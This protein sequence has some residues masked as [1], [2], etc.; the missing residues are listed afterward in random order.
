MA[1]TVPEVRYIST[2]GGSPPLSFTETLLAGLAPD[3]GLYVP[4]TYPRL[5]H[6]E[7]EAFA[8]KPYTRVA[9]AVIAP[10]V[11]EEIEPAVLRAMIEAS[12]S[13]FRH[14]AV[15]PLVQIGHDLFVLE[16]FHGPTLAFKDLAMQILARLVDH[17][18]AAQGRR[19]TIIGA[20][21]GDTGA[22]A[23]EA[24]RGLPR[25]DVFI[26][27]PH[28]RVS[29]V[30]RRQMTTVEAPNIHTIAIEGT[31]DD[32]QRCVKTLFNN[33]RLRDEFGLCGVNSINIARIL[34]QIVYYFTS[35]TT[36]GAP[37]RKVSFAVPTG[38]FGDILA[39]W[40]AKRMGLPVG[41][42]VIGANSND[43][44]ARTLATGSYA[45]QGVRATQSPSMDIQ[46]S[47]NF[48]RLLFEAHGRDADA[49]RRLMAGLDQ[50]GA[51]TIASGP[52][53]AIRAEF[54][55]F[56]VSESETTQEIART[57]RESSYVADPHTAVGI[58]A[59][60][61]A[62]AGDSCAARIVLGTAHPAKFPDAIEAAIGSRPALPRH[63][64][65]ISAAKEN[66]RVLPNDQTEI[67]KFVVSCVRE[68][69]AS[70]RAV[71]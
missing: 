44:L 58:A 20:T 62:S 9:E 71:T 23:I 47:S 33:T 34:A 54:D 29:E 40:I 46:V 32:A 14:E 37:H 12:Y 15:A 53:E 2:R 60:R 41:R 56:S 27:Y 66:F 38:N 5:G 36:L 59:A 10:F 18:L 39:G 69:R 7:I 51:F 70:E 52:L 16:L 3:G 42:L 68:A 48:E 61:H 13:A 57:Y 65:G 26:F 19:A 28:G 24:F 35:A 67:E 55:A 22:A 11:G 63:L 8:G 45:V 64:S 30:Q 4:E 43:I 50:S 49:V 6:D 25:V 1:G 31:F 17:A 21:S